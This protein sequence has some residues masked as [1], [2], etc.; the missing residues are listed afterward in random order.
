M[1]S[2]ETHPLEDS[3][4]IA[5][6]KIKGNSAFVVIEKESDKIVA[7]KRAVPLVCGKNANEEDLF[8][9]SDPYALIG[10]ATEIFFPEDEVVCILD[11]N[12][13]E[14]IRFIELDYSPSKRVLSQKQ[15]KDLPLN[16]KGEF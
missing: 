7:V 14:K 16:N 13:P 10:Y 3:V 11:R 5:F 12:V 4:I 1:K 15:D 2:L 9:S 8:I 6:Q